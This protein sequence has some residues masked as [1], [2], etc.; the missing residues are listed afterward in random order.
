M[1]FPVAS[2]YIGIRCGL[3]L[4]EY[5]RV[6][7]TT[8]QKGIINSNG[9]FTKCSC[10]PQGHLTKDEYDAIIPMIVD[11]FVANGIYATA[12]FFEKDKDIHKIYDSLKCDMTPITKI[13]A[14]K[15]S[16]TNK[17]PRKYMP[18][19]Y[20]VSDHM[21]VSI[22]SQW[23]AENIA[24][25]FEKLNIPTIT[26]GSYF[27]EFIK[28]LKFSPVTIYSPIMT[29]R[30]LETLNC[31]TI[32]DPCIGWGGR[33]LGTTALG[34]SYY[35]GCEPC[36]RTFS[37]LQAMCSK[38]NLDP[39]VE[40]YNEPVEDVLERLT[41][42]TY[43]ACLTS[44]PYYN[45][46]VY[47]QEESQSVKR[48]PT[49][50]EWRAKF[51]RPIIDYVC[52]HVTKYSCWSVKDFKTDNQYN[53]LADVIDDHNENGWEKVAEYSIGKNT[54]GNKNSKGDT[55][56]IFRKMS[57]IALNIPSIGSLK[58]PFLLKNP[59]YVHTIPKARVAQESLMNDPN[60][61]D[62]ER[63][64]GKVY[65]TAINSTQCNEPYEE[66]LSLVLG[67]KNRHEKHGWDAI[68]EDTQENYEYK[69]TK[70]ISSKD[71]VTSS[72]S[73]NDDTLDRINRCRGD[74]TSQLVIAII[75]KNTSKYLMICKFPM[76]ILNDHREEFYKKEKRRNAN[77]I[78]YATSIQK[79]IQH[80]LKQNVEFYEWTS[81]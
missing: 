58:R 39:Q 8:G 6:C 28:K 80:C 64:I 43:D 70:I 40:L 61:S 59:E 63:H 29:K 37:G 65:L 22:S 76:K 31:R 45:L 60:T 3:H 42:N 54:Q 17:I 38:F 69:P 44:P 5:Q 79:C 67:L 20:D 41:G 24:N 26:N 75:D 19:I 71:P 32:F 47:S 4:K 18:H 35:V 50:E 11:E 68:D 7:P 2:Q 66:N 56:Y 74:P 10:P 77:R 9:K 55:T 46:E 73:I 13:N 34:S 78:V 25:G 33:M 52:S 48:Y 14:Q 30:L 21:G 49:Y 16:H 15:T 23:T 72:V 51:L 12:E 27:T 81:D 53:L 36:A 57:G 1:S 62:Q